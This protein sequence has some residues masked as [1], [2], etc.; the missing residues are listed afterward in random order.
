MW[1]IV[2][3]EVIDGLEENNSYVFGLVTMSE[4]CMYQKTSGVDG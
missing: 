1:G 2:R 4:A 3:V